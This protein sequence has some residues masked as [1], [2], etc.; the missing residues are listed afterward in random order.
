MS[1]PTLLLAT[2]HSAGSA[3]AAQWAHAYAK[4]HGLSV[5]LAHVIEL[6]VPNWLRDA[7]TIPD[8]AGRRQAM[9]KK[10]TDWYAKHT[11]GD[12]PAG[13]RIQAGSPY[14]TLCEMAQAEDVAL[15]VVAK[16]GKG[17]ITR[18]LAGSTAQMLAA[19]PPAPVAIVHPDCVVLDAST[20]IAVATDL[21][22]TA[23]EAIE[24]AV[25]LA[26]RLG[27]PLDIVHASRVE[28]STELSGLGPDDLNL[29][30]RT[31][32]DQVIASHPGLSEITYDVHIVERDP[33]S[34]M[35][36]FVDA[37]QS[38]VVFLGNA[39]SYT[40]VKNVFG[41][42]S[43]KLTQILPATVIVVPPKAS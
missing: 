13:I 9:E 22:H 41:R 2:D 34:A 27:A 33:V 4:A 15:V 42:V 31:Q 18:M 21:T 19:T 35:S 3:F 10:L 12:T 6:S 38:D 36:E 37:R 14:E 28:S 24:Q 16:S 11:G 25:A 23:E 30:T 39:A 43:V 17:K 29:K 8:D 20:K 5:V 26:Q 7:Y 1:N 40:L 32:V